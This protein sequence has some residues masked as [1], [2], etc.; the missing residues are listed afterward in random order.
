MDYLLTV[1]CSIAEKVNNEI[2]TKGLKYLDQVINS[3][4]SGEFLILTEKQMFEL[5][6]DYIEDYCMQ[7]LSLWSQFRKSLNENLNKILNEK[8][9]YY[10]DLFLESNNYFADLEKKILND[11]LKDLEL[12]K[13]SKP[14]KSKILIVNSE[15]KSLIYFRAEHLKQIKVESPMDNSIWEKDEKTIK[16]SKEYI[17]SENK[18]ILEEVLPKRYSIKRIDIRPIG[19]EILVTV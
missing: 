3:K 6:N 2:F 5:V 12:K 13:T 4:Y 8:K 14:I 1:F 17:R 10:D 19:I 16:L 15:Q 9:Q 7:L 18:R 11:R